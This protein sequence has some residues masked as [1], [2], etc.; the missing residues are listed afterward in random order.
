MGCSSIKTP[1]LVTPIFTHLALGR[2]L[3]ITI[4]PITVTWLV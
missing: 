3:K 2:S 1:P 4:D